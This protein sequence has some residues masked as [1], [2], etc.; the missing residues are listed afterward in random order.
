MHIL[1]IS[2]TFRN[3]NYRI[4]E[5]DGCEASTNTFLINDLDF[6]FVLLIATK[7]MIHDITIILKQI[8]HSVFILETK[9]R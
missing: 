2:R 9:P 4:Y 6:I 3:M 1:G 8:S 5:R 7:Y